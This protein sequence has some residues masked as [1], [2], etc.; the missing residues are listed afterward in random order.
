V[1]H[2]AD[3]H[4]SVMMPSGTKVKILVD[5]KKYKRRINTS[6]I[7]KLYSDVDGDDEAHAGLLVSQESP[8]C[9]MS[10]FE[11]SRTPK[12]K[13]VMFISFDG[14][15]M[16]YRQ[17]MLLWAVRALVEVCGA[18]DDD[19]KDHMLKDIEEFLSELDGSVK[20]IDGAMRTMTKSI[21][22]LKEARNGIVRK[23][24]KFRSGAAGDDAVDA[25]VALVEGCGHMLKSGRRCGK[26]VSG[27]GEALCKAHAAKDEN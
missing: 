14:V 17:D 4:L 6:E 23:M 27:A 8:I 21:E 13:P 9:T 25:A 10:Q 24:V 11:V 1:S 7:E 16:D 22:A 18:I 19:D 2:A 3:F 20:D 26:K 12:Q 15:S 5:S